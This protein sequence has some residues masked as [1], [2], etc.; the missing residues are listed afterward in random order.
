MTIHLGAVKISYDNKDFADVGWIRKTEKTAN[1]FRKVGSDE[2]LEYFLDT[3]QL[4]Q[5][6]SQW[7]FRDAGCNNAANETH[8]NGDYKEGDVS[9]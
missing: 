1:A 7:D 3:E 9:F 2:G 8:S 5:N 6:V 4:K